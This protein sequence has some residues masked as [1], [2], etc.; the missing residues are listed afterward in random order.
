MPVQTR[1]MK[2]KS[3]NRPR[4]IV[5]VNTANDEFV[6]VVNPTN[7]FVNVGDIGGDLGLTLLLFGG[8]AV[9][10]GFWA[11]VLSEGSRRY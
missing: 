11:V 5:F 4:R 9:G 8:L 1:S 3:A 10:V 6:N 2:K 7:E